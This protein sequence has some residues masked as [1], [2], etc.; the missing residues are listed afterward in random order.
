MD[1]AWLWLYL[2]TRFDALNEALSGIFIISLVVAGA[3]SLFA[4]FLALDDAWDEASSMFRLAKKWV[5]VV[6]LPALIGMVAFPTKSDMA[7]I[8]GGHFAGQV[9]VS[10]EMNETT[11][12]LY[13]LVQRELDERLEEVNDHE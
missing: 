4:I 6:T 8:L 1:Y 5:F 11:S 9:I 13:Q 7:I 3:V 2:W 12:K 10:E